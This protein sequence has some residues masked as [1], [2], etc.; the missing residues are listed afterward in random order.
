MSP[1]AIRP[2]TAIPWGRILSIAEYFE[3]MDYGPAPE[4]DSEVRAWLA[5]HK[6]SFG[7]F[8]G[9][10]FVSGAKQ[11]DTNEPATG[12]LLA[13]IADGSKKDIDAA[14]SAARKAQGP[15]EKLGGHG[16]ARH[17]YALARM[18]QR[19]ARLFAVL[20][21][22]DNGKPIR[23]TRDLG[24]AAGGAAFLSPRGLGA[25]AGQ[26]VIRLQGHWGRWPN[27]SVE[28]PAP[29]AG[30]EGG[31][32][33]GCRKHCCAEAG[34]IHAAYGPAVCRACPQGG[35]AAGR[36]ECGDRRGHYGCSA[37]GACRAWTRSPLPAPPK[38][39]A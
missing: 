25:I 24:C 10:K 6:S 1:A 27:H 31:A 34:G 29:H 33:L 4:S 30:V 36:S 17:L 20:E 18:L 3:T 11:I 22:L 2:S 14:V 9:G 15:W 23:E 21:S 32:G 13:R 37:S 39:A 38:W 28:F 8:I 7:H 26:R 5:T 12:K 19:H 16:R 35:L